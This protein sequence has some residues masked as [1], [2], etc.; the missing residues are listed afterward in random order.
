[1]RVKLIGVSDEA[2]KSESVHRAK[3]DCSPSKSPSNSPRHRIHTTSGMSKEFVGF[4]VENKLF[5]STFS[6]QGETQ[7]C[8]LADPNEAASRFTSAT[9]PRIHIVPA[10]FF[11]SN[12]ICSSTARFHP[13][14]KIDAV[15][16]YDGLFR[17][18]SAELI[19]TE[20]RGPFPRLEDEQTRTGSSLN[21]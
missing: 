7:M 15:S 2:R 14:N 11:G 6:R 3:R 4:F 5:H 8:S 18:F 13:V 10:R 16:L 9:G 12:S 21:C 19:T 17:Q 20:P 1:M